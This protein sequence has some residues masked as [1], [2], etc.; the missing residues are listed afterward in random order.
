[1]PLRR[2]RPESV[3]Q[4]EEQRTRLAADLE[5][6]EADV[7]VAGEA[8]GEA[9]KLDAAAYLGEVE[10]QVA[11]AAITEAQGAHERAVEALARVRSYGPELEERIAAAHEAARAEQIAALQEALKAALQQR[12]KASEAV[13]SSLK[14]TVAAARLLVEARRDVDARRDAVR[15][16]GG[17][18]RALETDEVEWPAGTDELVQTLQAGPLRPLER[19]QRNL[20]RYQQDRASAQR[21]LAVQLVENAG[22]HP[23]GPSRDRLLAQLDEPLRSKTLTRVEAER[24]RLRAVIEQK[25]AG[26]GGGAPLERI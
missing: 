18:H 23:P 4:L 2:K 22:V 7:A 14:G 6:A 8:L 24:D 11:E 25:P 13:V 26:L 15:Q 5:R 3:A 10:P 12:G 16:A 9:R 20:E 19:A 21:R 1:M 17:D